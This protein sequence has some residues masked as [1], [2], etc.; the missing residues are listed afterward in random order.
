MRRLP[1]LTVL[2]GIGCL[3]QTPSAL[4]SDPTG[5]Q[6]IMPP[7][8]FAGWTRLP[9]L[10]TNPMDA[11]SQWKVDENNHVLLCEG[12]R[13]HEWLRYDTELADVIFH[14]E[15]RFAKIDGGKGYNS[16]V[17]VRNNA[18]GTIW[19]QVQAGEEGTGYLF[20]STPVNG[21]PQRFNLRAAMK[22]NRVKPAGEWNVYELRA[23]GPKIT[24]WVNGGVTSEKPDVAA[25][26][27]Y[28]GLEAEGYRV[29]F[30]NIRLKKLN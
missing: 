24:V 4:E 7:A 5:W 19:H 26:K 9:F 20:G 28:V 21:Q 22:E 17:M 6:D 13:G 27:G 2:L 23:A 1:I 16:G 29:E 14:A 25:L 11:V 30:R 12:N 18:D 8:S 10:T 3:A 15:F